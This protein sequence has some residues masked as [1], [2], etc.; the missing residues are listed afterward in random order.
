MEVTV[1]KKKVRHCVTWH[2]LRSDQDFNFYIE[3]E[4]LKTC[5]LKP[6]TIK[7]WHLR[8]RRNLSYRLAQLLQAVAVGSGP[9][10]PCMYCPEDP[11]GHGDLRHVPTL[12]SSSALFLLYQESWVGGCWTMCSTNEMHE[13][14]GEAKRSPQ[15]SRLVSTQTGQQ[16][17][18]PLSTGLPGMDQV[19]GRGRM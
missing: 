7:L 15:V 11:V 14:L 16:G 6:T 9:G 10:V 1:L 18:R 17:C 12:S 19:C 8:S 2:V 5:F 4:A 13:G 3:D